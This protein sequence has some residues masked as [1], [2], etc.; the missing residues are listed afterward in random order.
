MRG[1]FVAMDMSEYKEFFNKMQQAAQRDLRKEFLRYLDGLGYEFLRI[2]QDEIIRRQVVD[3]RLLLHSFEKG[4]T[5]NLWTIKEAGLALE[6]GSLVDYAQ[7]VNDGHWTN[8]KGQE[9]RFVP[10]YWQGDRFIYS[11]GAKTGMYLK[12][13]WVEGAHYWDSAVRIMERVFPKLLERQ[14]Q[15]WLNNY[16][17]AG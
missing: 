10:G 7:Y 8:K 2:V 6:V 12:Q 13:K 5:S 14:M 15:E 11:P 4:D 16:F 1:E 9:G 3:T 17:K